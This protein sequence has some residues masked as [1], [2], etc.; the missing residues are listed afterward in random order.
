MGRSWE[1]PRLALLL[2]FGLVAAGA[3]VVLAATGPRPVQ[4]VI[5]GLFGVALVVGNRLAAEMY[6]VMWGFAER[7]FFY[8]LT[9]GAAI[10]SGLVAVVASLVNGLQ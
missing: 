4:L 6:V 2:L 9:R 7:G 1:G 5:F 3:V 10:V 8:W